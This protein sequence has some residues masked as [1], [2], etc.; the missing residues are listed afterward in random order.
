M[1]PFLSTRQCIIAAIVVLLMLLAGSPPPLNPALAQSAPTTSLNPTEGPPGTEVTI[2][3]SGWVAGET[4]IIQFAISCHGDN[5][6][7]SEV[8]QVT[9]GDG[10]TFVTTFTVPVDA[11]I[12]EQKVIAGTAAVSQQTDAVFRVTGE[13]AVTVEWALTAAPDEPESASGHEKTTFRPG[14][15]I[16][17]A[18][19][20][21]N[22][23]P[24]G[25]CRFHLAREA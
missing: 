15:S 10:K 2:Q 25:R 21:R 17:Y 11:A 4:V 24:V 16:W 7:F 20:V 12:G 8:A 13:P 23:G 6:T 3:G 22:S 18:V 19:V 14:D 9:V 5:L 1:V